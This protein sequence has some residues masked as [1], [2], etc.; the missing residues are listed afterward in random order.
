MNLVDTILRSAT[1]L[2]PFPEV[3][4]RVL[5][6]ME[7]P[8]ASS[9]DVVEVIQYDQAITANVL[10][11]CNSAYFGLR[12][13]VLSLGEALIRIG[14]N[15]LVE[16]VL[17]RGT[18]PLFSQACQGY[19]LMAGELWR[20]SVACALLSEILVARLKRKK[21]PVQFTTAL[22]HDVGKRVL[23][24]FVKDGFEEIQ[25]LVQEKNLSFLEAEKEVL[26]IDHAEL[27]GRIAELWKFPPDI[28]AGIRFH[29]TPL[30]ASEFCDLVSLVHLCDIVAL[31]TGVG[32]GADGLSYH[33]YKGVMK[34][35]GLREKDLEGV[36]SDL[37]SGMKRVEEIMNLR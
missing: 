5:Q 11:V 31:M 37:A 22:L 7:D 14:F 1:H 29:H 24:E 18:A 8:K 17:T 30:L 32:G 19:Q 25:R 34:Q 13:P 3:V 4:H 33:C 21:A 6:V 23:S 20:H 35:Y 16:I 9:H 12:N 10:R 15:H 28:I 36:I 26:G 2:P 27:G